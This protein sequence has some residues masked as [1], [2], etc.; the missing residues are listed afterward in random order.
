MAL[1]PRTMDRE[2]LI[3]A[4]SYPLESYSPNSNPTYRLRCGHH[5]CFDCIA[6]NLIITLRTMPF[7][8]VQ[9]CERM[10]MDLIRRVANL[11]H[12]LTPADLILYRQRLS[13]YDAP[14]KLYCWDPKCSAFIP[15]V[16]V[17]G[18]SAKCRKCSTKTCVKCGRKFHFGSCTPTVA[19]FRRTLAVADN[20]SAAA[21]A[22]RRWEMDLARRKEE[23]IRQQRREERRRKEEDMFKR[24]SI[25]QGWKACPECKRMVEKTEGC[26]H[27][28]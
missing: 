15:P 11:S 8:P 2:C 4:T 10:S 19:A 26:N 22:T 23:L 18:H 6:Q 3:C 24:L 12:A 13:E 1:S 9:C 5:H 17:Q 14:R 16:L 21:A 20:A 28:L 25:G 27:I 7:R